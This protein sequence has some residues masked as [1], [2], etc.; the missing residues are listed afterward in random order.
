[1]VL[2]SSAIIHNEIVN[3]LN[4]Y[5]ATVFVTEDTMYM[6][7]LGSVCLGNFLAEVTI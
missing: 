2:L 1:M 6:P 4:E 3:T 5:F 7:S